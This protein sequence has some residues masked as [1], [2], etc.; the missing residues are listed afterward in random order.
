[1]NGSELTVCETCNSRQSGDRYGGYFPVHP[2]G[3]STADS[4]GATAAAARSIDPV[5][6]I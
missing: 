1:M 3:A 4:S 5:V 2:A 6:T